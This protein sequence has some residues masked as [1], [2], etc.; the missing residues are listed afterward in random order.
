[1]NKN[2]LENIIRD[3]GFTAIFRKIG[4]VGDS[5]SSGEHESLDENGV[6]GYNDYYE[7]SWG[8][9][10]GRA[11]GSEVINFSRGGM[12][13]KEFS[14]YGGHTCCFT[15]ER[16]CQAYIIALG[17]NDMNQVKQGNI[18]FGS[19]EDV[20]FEDLEKNRSTFVG[21]YVRV[22]Q[23]LRKNE[24]K[25]RIFVTTIP[26]SI[27]GED[28]EQRHEMHAE[29]IRELP[30]YFDF[31]YVI[32]LR[33]YAPVHDEQWKKIYLLGGHLSAMGYKYMADLFG[34]YVDYIIRNN[35]DDFKQVGFIGKGIHNVSEKW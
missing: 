24:P 32:D 16:A 25:C 11:C 4:C 12:T 26:R 18:E 19:M 9:F 17:A 23:R 2:P 10:L 20:D 7:Y 30:K 27:N 31:L 13:A 8:Q 34:T 22:I 14:P 28:E 35:P 29:F 5:L 6:K 3:G 33:K 1:M 15:P 21:E